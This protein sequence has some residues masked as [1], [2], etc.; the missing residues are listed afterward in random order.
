[1]DTTKHSETRAGGVGR[2]IG[3][4]LAAAG[5]ILA[6]PASLT[7]GQPLSRLLNQVQSQASALQADDRSKRPAPLVLKSGDQKGSTMFVGH[8]SHSSHSSHRSH[9]SH[10]SHYSS[11][12]YS[13]RSNARGSMSQDPDSAADLP[14]NKRSQ[15][16]AAS[17]QGPVRGTESSGG[18][19]PQSPARSSAPVIFSAEPFDATDPQQRFQLLSLSRFEGGSANKGRPERGALSHDFVPATFASGDNFSGGYNI[20]G[21]PAGDNICLIDSVGSQANRIEPLFA[22]E[23]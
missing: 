2:K 1:M 4:L 13:T 16:K 21:D 7:A 23:K 22:K 11:A 17:R 5:A 10:Q 15:K 20:D 18:T 19:L 6:Q 9:A 3:T 14:S 8:R 12:S